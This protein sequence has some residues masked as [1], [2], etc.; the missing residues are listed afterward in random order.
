MHTAGRYRPVAL[1][2]EVLVKRGHMSIYPRHTPLLQSPSIVGFRRD[3]DAIS[4][5]LDNGLPRCRGLK[6]P[7]VFSRVI[8]RPSDID[9]GS[10]F[11]DLHFPYLVG[12]GVLMVNGCSTVVVLQ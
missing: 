2:Q 10:A 6:L 11:K 7:L 12:T 1:A 5:G 3:V 8:N 4:G 9:I